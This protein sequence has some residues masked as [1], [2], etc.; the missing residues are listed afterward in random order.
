MA[1]E[2]TAFED[3]TA[4]AGVRVAAAASLA[5]FVALPAA[6]RASVVLT[7]VLG[8]SLAETAEILDISVAAVKANVHRGRTQL[9]ARGHQMPALPGVAAG[10]KQRLQAYADLFNAREFDALRD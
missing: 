8:Y 7:D 10:E 3:P 6:Q 2:I 9:R 5:A 1:E 4:D